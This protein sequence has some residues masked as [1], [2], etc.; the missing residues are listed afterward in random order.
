MK[1]KDYQYERPNMDQIKSEIESLLSEFEKAS[2]AEEQIGILKKINAVRNHFDTMGVIVDIRFT[3]NT[4]DPFY[5]KETDYFD[6]VRPEFEALTNAIYR[7][8]DQSPYKEALKETFGHQLFDLASVTLKTF[9]DEILADLKEENAL[10]SEYT[11]LRSSAK[12]MFDGEER[13]LAQMTPY[14]ESEDREVRK[15]SQEAVSE[16]FLENE[17]AFDSVYD[18]MVK[19][20]HRIAQKLGYD[21]FV[22]VAYMRLNR[23]EYDSQMVAGYR[24][25][26]LDNIVPIATRLK[27]R[28]RERLGLETLYYYDEPIAFKSGNA[29][30]KGNP[31]W[32]LEKGKQMYEELSPET[33]EFINF[34][35]DHEL[36]DLVAK[37][38]K[39]GGGYCTYLADYQAPFIFSNFNGT[40]GDVDVL[41]HEA[42]HAFQGYQSRQF[43]VPEYN[44]PTLE[45]CEIHSM[46]ME[47][48]TWPWMELFFENETEKYKFNHLSEALLFLPYGVLV[49]EFQHYVYENPNVSPDER[50][51]KWRELE[52]K[53]L[54]HR[55]YAENQILDKGAFWFRQ[56]HIFTDPFYYIDYTLAQVCAF[57][58]FVKFNEDRE[59]AWSDYLKLCNAGGSKPFLELVELANLKNPFVKGT[60]ESVVPDIVAFLDHVDDKAL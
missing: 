2:S 39:S 34:M 3:I 6:D 28:Q 21:N 23:T 8:L 50:K 35:L 47:F 33:G 54:P 58:F 1:F 55:N 41:T 24:Q 9:K 37:K 29:K 31:D 48:I 49:D 57:Q 10:M 36:M 17:A 12:I 46:S 18:R 5:S 53:Y 25:Q 30:P 4:L 38:G 42:G 16:F 56:G 20:R 13:N 44:Y 22:P 59:S 11:K 52:H 51:A 40:S 32:I 26:I 7:K 14:Y 27:E 45:A 43:E 60:V 19:V 15:A